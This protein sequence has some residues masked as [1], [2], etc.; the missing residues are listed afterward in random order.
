M[1][2]GSQPALAYDF[3]G[4]ASGINLGEML[5]STAGTNQF[6][7]AIKVTIDGRLNA[8]GI[9]LRGAGAT[10]SQL[11]SSMAGGAQLSGHISPGPTGR[12]RCWARR[13]PESRAA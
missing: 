8:S 9:T 6:G 1:V 5:R 11:K 7:G 4:D 2:N 10:S 12:C 13:R 3:K